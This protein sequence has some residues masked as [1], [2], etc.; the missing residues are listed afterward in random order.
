MNDLPLSALGRSLVGGERDLTGSS[1]V[2]SA[3]DERKCLVDSDGHS[4]ASSF[5]VVHIWSL[6]AREVGSI[7]N[8][9]TVVEIT[10]AVRCWRCH[11]HVSVCGGK[12]SDGRSHEDNLNGSHSGRSC[13]K[14]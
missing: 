12:E 1:S 10:F 9:R 3:S 6:F 13:R 2:Y 5:S 7:C 4:V 14:V 11:H 8:K